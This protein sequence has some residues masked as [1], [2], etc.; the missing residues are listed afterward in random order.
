MDQGK[1]ETYPQPS[2]AGGRREAARRISDTPKCRP[3]GHPSYPLTRPIPAVGFIYFNRLASW[4]FVLMVPHFAGVMDTY[5]DT[6]KL[7]LVSLVSKLR[8]WGIK[9]GKEKGRAETLPYR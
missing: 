2:K 9:Q 4:L 6:P 1:F 3:P 5:T 7:D 8:V